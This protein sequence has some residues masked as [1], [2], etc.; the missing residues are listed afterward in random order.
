[1]CGA[2][3]I[4]ADSV[5]LQKRAL[6]SG[7]IGTMFAIASVAGPLLGGVFTDSRLTWRWYVQDFYLSRL[8]TTRLG[9]RNNQ[10]LLH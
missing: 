6:Y 10:V 1:M 4:L 9:L 7:L 3:I 5:P 8:G 2:L